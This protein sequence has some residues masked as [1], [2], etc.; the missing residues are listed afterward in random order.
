[1]VRPHHA[2]HLGEH[3]PDLDVAEREGAA[4]DAEDEVLHAE[5]EDLGVDDSVRLPAARDHQ[6]PRAVAVELGDGFEEVEEV[7]AV[8]FVEGG[9]EAGVDED[10]LRAVA[11]GVDALELLRPG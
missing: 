6:V 2:Q 9:D 1:M 3:V 7:G 5:R 11:L 10:Q 8:R 4:L